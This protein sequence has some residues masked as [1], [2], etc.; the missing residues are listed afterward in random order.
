MK[1][2]K[3][4]KTSCDKVSLQSSVVLSEKIPWMQREDLLGPKKRYNS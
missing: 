2:A 4:K 3:H 1:P